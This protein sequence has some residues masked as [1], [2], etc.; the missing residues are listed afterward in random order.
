[1]YFTFLN[2]YY[3]TSN[4]WTNLKGDISKLPQIDDLYPQISAE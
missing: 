4:D 2:V 1:M 3:N